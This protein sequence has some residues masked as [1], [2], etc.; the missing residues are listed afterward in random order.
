MGS[1]GLEMGLRNLS[2]KGLEVIA[3][4]GV[5]NHILGARY[6]GSLKLEREL[7]CQE[8]QESQTL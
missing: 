5:S 2:E 6:V 1:I 8:C 3:R 4:N 7:Q